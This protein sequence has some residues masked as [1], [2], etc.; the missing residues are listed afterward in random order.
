MA[1]ALPLPFNMT[2]IGMI[3]C[4]LYTSL[5]RSIPMVSQG[6]VATWTLS[7]P[8]AIGLAGA[9]FYDQAV[10]FDPLANPFGLIASNA[11]QGVVGVK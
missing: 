4:T 10:V 1:G 2:I 7:V 3:G 6:G 11:Q 8:N 9:Q 5:D